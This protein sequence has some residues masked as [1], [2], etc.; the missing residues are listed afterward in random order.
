MDDMALLVNQDVGIVPVFHLKGY[1]IVNTSNR[2][3]PFLNSYNAAGTRTYLEKVGDNRVSRKAPHEVVLGSSEGGGVPLSIHS[4][5]VVTEV[6]KFR[7]LL[8]DMIN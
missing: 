2:S 8:L 5:V 1:A 4:M 3:Q 6:H 7:C